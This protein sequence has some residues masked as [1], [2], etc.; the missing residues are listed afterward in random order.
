[1]ARHRGKKALYEVMSKAR[2][3][4]GAGKTIEPLHP[5]KSEQEEKQQKDKKP[6]NAKLQAA[7][8]ASIL[9]PE[10]VQA[11]AKAETPWWKKP[12]ILQLNAGRIEFSLPYQIA[13]VIV[14]GLI[15]LVLIIFRLGQLS[16]ANQV[17]AE[18]VKELANSARTNQSRQENINRTPATDAALS[19]P[20]VRQAPVAAQ[21]TGN[22]V[23]VLKE[24]GAMADL[25]PARQYFEKNGIMTEIV[26]EN[27]RYFL[28]T[29]NTYDNPTTPGTDGYDE[30]I[31]IIKVGNGYKAPTGF[32]TFNFKDAYGKKV[33]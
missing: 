26:L 29:V 25:E 9:Q 17:T 20:Q 11:S 30:R 12:R 21:S 14:L 22:N 4:P 7:P 3:K 28:Q 13:V 10:S 15:A 6:V 31:R 2:V 19:R 8:S 16:M 24:Y 5:N 1:M 32:E 18:P 33:K 23:I 27:G